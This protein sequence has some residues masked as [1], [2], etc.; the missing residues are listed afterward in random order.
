MH[1]YNPLAG[2]RRERALG[3]EVPD[4][5]PDQVTVAFN[6]ELAQAHSQLA[7]ATPAMAELDRA[8]ADPS[9]RA[10]L[11]QEAAEQHEVLMELR[12]GALENEQISQQGQRIAL[13]DS[14][15]VWKIL[16][17]GPDYTCLVYTSDAADQ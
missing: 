7:Q 1:L 9:H 6:P 4:W 17:A 12:A 8:V 15:K 11:E 16:L 2:H 3:E 5:D 10:A 13:L 14:D